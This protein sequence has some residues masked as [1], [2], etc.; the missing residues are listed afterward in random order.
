M[1]RVAKIG[2][3]KQVNLVLTLDETGL[4]Q[5]DKLDLT[6]FKNNPDEYTIVDIR[7]QSETDEG[8]YFENAIHI[9]LNELRNSKNHIP[10][11]RSIVVHCEGGYR[12]AV[13][14][15]VVGNMHDKANVFDLSE[16]INNFKKTKR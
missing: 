12:S 2:Y 10:T 3:E 13:G 11:D 6:H 4:L 14:S 8:R 7:N 9:P 15:S 16:N 5:S 1:E